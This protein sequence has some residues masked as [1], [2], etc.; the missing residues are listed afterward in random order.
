MLFLNQTTTSEISQFVNKKI[1]LKFPARISV[2][3]YLTEALFAMIALCVHLFGRFRLPFFQFS[4]QY[5]H[6]YTAILV[7]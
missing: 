1:A 3:V 7:R 4:L 6:R 2:G 5:F